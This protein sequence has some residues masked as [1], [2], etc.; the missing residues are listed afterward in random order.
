VSTASTRPAVPGPGSLTWRYGGDP[1]IL[2][3]AGYALLLQLAHPT[4]AAG[5]RDHSDY[6]S[7]PW[8]RLLRT[9]DHL[10]LMTFGGQAAAEKAAEALRRG[11]ES[12]RGAHADG[13]KYNAFEPEAWAWVQA[14]LAD[15]AITGIEWFAH[16]L[17]ASERD[18]LWREALIGAELVG[19]E[20][21]PRDWAG[22]LEYRE[23]MIA[24]R[25]QNDAA[26]GEFLA[27][28]DKQFGSAFAAL[29]AIG[30]LPSALRIKCGLSWTHRKQGQ[31]EALA[32]V[33]RAMSPLMVGPLRNVGPM[34][35]RWR[36]LPR[37]EAHR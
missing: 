25:L 2:G 28:L 1:R 3:A 31:L 5:V 14:T 20:G 35:L 6:A 4:V 27:T 37:G 36:G 12:I 7:D 11:H 17:T 29:P 15:A 19:A 32:R 23:A 9:I 22:Y 33:S 10:Y 30:L 18:G 8:G 21:L 26:I 34:Y 16:P 24:D 13:T